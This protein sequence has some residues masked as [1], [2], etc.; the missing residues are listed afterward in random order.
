MDLGDKFLTELLADLKNNRLNLPILPEV[1]LK[2]RR[3]VE[4]GTA[5]ATLI[6]RTVGTD[7]SL[8][9]RLI[10][11]A[12]SPLF[13]GTSKIDNLQTAVA[14][15]GNDQVRSLVTSLIMRQV[16]QT[17]HPALR[18]RMQELWLHS[19]EV[20][21]ISQVLARRYTRLNPEQAM[22]AGLIH[23]IGA[24][25][26]LARAESA[27]V[28]ALD[29]AALDD[30]I[31]KLHTVL[32]RVILET[33]KFP[34]ELVAVVAQHED[35]GYQSDNGPDYVDVVLVANLHS[36]IGTP[37]RHGKVA[38]AEIPA[39]ARLGLTPAESLKAM[40]ETRRDIREI[41]TLLA[42]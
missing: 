18:Q 16:Y 2:V 6:A 33:W 42:A 7:A 5:N 25:P 9:A 37:H 11:V 24:L 41:Q 17:R 4:D 13:R 32:G 34:P 19:T 20:A 30:V 3:V 23:D 35:L 12:N 1:A 8:S 36:R 14:R 40:E 27:A 21:A 38:W 22:L 39:F 15:L 26:I 29:P 10:Q 28:P 31:E